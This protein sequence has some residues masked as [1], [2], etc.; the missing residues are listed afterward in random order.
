[1]Q[2]LLDFHPIQSHSHTKRIFAIL[3]IWTPSQ[4]F[5]SHCTCA[6]TPI[7]RL[8]PSGRGTISRSWWLF[9]AFRSLIPTSRIRRDWEGIYQKGEGL[10]AG[11]ERVEL[12]IKGKSL[13]AEA[14]SLLFFVR[15]QKKRSWI[16][17]FIR[18]AGYMCNKII[19][20]L[21]HR[22]VGYFPSDVFKRCCH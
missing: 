18:D 15:A 17:S 9:L 6:F 11:L 5:T 4:M 7:A 2:H 14:E 10:T 21:Q 13:N 1:M 20:G 19:P 8:L 16:C 22:Q 12:H 3:T